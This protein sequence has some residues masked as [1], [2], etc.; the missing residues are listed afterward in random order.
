MPPGEGRLYRV[1]PVVLHGG[2][3]LYDE[4]AYGGQELTDDMIIENGATL[5]IYDEYVANANIIVKNGS[6]VT[7]E[8]GKIHFAPISGSAGNKLNLEFEETTGENQSGIVIQEGGS[9]TIAN[10]QVDDATIGINSLLNADYL[11][12]QYV[13]FINCRDYSINIAGRSSGENPTLPRKLNTAQLQVQIMV[14]Q[15]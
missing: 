9:L 8:N 6:I 2:R 7:G 5:T 10:C 12:A 15:Y 11:N 4:N 13:D 14:S 1:S 3:L